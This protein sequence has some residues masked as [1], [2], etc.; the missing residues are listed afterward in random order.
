MSETRSGTVILGVVLA[1]MAA[2]LGW[3]I[4]GQY[5]HETGAMMAG[6]LFSLVIVFLYGDRLTSLTGARAAALCALG[7][8]IGG[9]M[10]Y[11]QT[12]GLTKD[13]PLIGNWE[14]LQWGM[15]GLFIKGGIWI[16]YGGA[17]L[18]IGLSGI[19]YRPLE[20]VLL[21]L[22][23]LIVFFF[24]VWLLNS[25]FDPANK[26]LPLIYFSD[27]FKF[28]PEDAK[29]RPEVWGGLL[30]ALLTLLGYA[31]IGKRDRLA[32]RLGVWGF[33]AGG[34]GFTTGQG[35][36]SYHAWNPDKFA[37]GGLFGELPQYINWWNFMETGFGALWGG[38][39][40]LGVGLNRRLIV[41]AEDPDIVEISRPAE[42]LLFFVHMA[43]IVAH[44]FHEII[45]FGRPLLIPRLDIF[46]GHS[47]TMI[48]IP[49]TCVQAGRYWP[50]LMTLPVIA[51]PICG[52]TVRELCYNTNPPELPMLYGVLAY[53]VLPLTLL[54]L[55]AVLL[56][57]RGMFGKGARDFA[58]WALLMT[59]W[60]Y[61]W[62][63]FAFF[64][65]PWPWDPV[66]EWTG[67][68]P[69]GL[70]FAICAVVLSLAALTL[71]WKRSEDAPRIAGLA[72]KE[73]PVKPTAQRAPDA[74]PITP[75]DP[76]PRKDFPTRPAPGSDQGRQKPQKP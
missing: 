2:G 36:Q 22:A 20:L 58:R 63:N 53:I 62:L 69:N 47:L 37:E 73:A 51:V 39:L 70:V 35:I 68:T 21:L 26:V 55:L 49:V 41:S 1:A 19:R 23:M 10:T 43:S 24:G 31:R 42:W 45:I 64:R 65:Y 34:I 30:L 8:S 29:P 33:L 48:L 59:T 57:R 11:A 25:P 72:A 6:V 76:P 17:L 12:V 4:R 56:A 67:R 54:I 74:R 14:A 38:I 32:L 75:K 71:G 60:V 5:G 13:A 28:E 44:E 16:S 52:K 40:A 27:N 18:G 15:L 3:G 50:Y 66:A 46:M 7:I 9:S 61:F